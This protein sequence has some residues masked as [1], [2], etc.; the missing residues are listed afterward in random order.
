MHLQIPC[1]N[2]RLR[3]SCRIRGSPAEVILPKP[4]VPTVPPGLEKFTLLNTLK[5]SARN[6][7]LARSVMLVF[8]IRPRFVLKNRGPRRIFL[9]ELPN[10]PMA[11]ATKSDVLKNRSTIWECDS[12]LSLAW[13]KSVPVKS[14]RSMPAELKEL[15]APVTRLKGKPFC[16]VVTEVS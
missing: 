4:G 1:Q 15:S 7:S 9:P 14:A 2:I 6:C 5:N 12:P 3:A 8:L 10:V 11:L 13:L 16:Q